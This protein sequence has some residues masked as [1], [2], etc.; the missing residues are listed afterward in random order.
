MRSPPTT[1]PEA[2]LR[3]AETL[4]KIPTEQWTRAEAA[5][6]PGD[7]ELQIVVEGLQ[8]PARG[9]FAGKRGIDTSDEGASRQSQPQRAQKRQ[10]GK[11]SEATARDFLGEERLG[12]GARGQPQPQRAEGVRGGDQIG[13]SGQG[14]QRD[15]KA[16]GR[17]VTSGTPSIL[18]SAETLAPDA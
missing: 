3:S 8:H 9:F 7:L 15:H 1:S 5:A 11:I 6:Y 4:A 13:L 14:R 10:S 18:L 16:S 12:A 2:S 17:R